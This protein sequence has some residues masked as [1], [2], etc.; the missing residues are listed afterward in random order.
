MQEDMNNNISLAHL[1]HQFLYLLISNFCMGQDSCFLFVLTLSLQTGLVYYEKYKSQWLKATKMYS[2]LMQNL[3]QV[4][5]FAGLGDSPG[6][7]T[8]V[9]ARQV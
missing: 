2:S 5:V 8:C 6:Q 7:V 3:L 4:W 1:S 9:L